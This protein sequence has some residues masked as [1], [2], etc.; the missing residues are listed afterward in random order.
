MLGWLIWSLPAMA[1]EGHSPHEG[2]HK[3]HGS[4]KHGS[5]GK[6][7]KKDMAAESMARIVMVDLRGH[8]LTF[9][10]ISGSG[11]IRMEQK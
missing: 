2:Q 8:R 5:Y 7:G 6:A 1:G 10:H 11:W 9:L 4:G 3:G